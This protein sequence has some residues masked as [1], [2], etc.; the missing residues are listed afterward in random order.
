[1]VTKIIKIGPLLVRLAVKKDADC[2]SGL[3]DCRSLTVRQLAGQFRTQNCRN[4]IEQKA[5]RFWSPQCRLMTAE[6]AIVRVAVLLDV[7]V[8]QVA[9]SIPHP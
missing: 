8:F 2:G 7:L 5:A 4:R 6:I 1:M 3:Q 9:G